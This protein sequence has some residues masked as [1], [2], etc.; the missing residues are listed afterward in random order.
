MAVSIGENP[1]VICVIC[2]QLYGSPPAPGLAT[3]TVDRG[4]LLM[5]RVCEE[6]IRLANAQR[7]RALMR[8]KPHDLGSDVRRLDGAKVVSMRAVSAAVRAA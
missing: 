5:S 8:M 4:P 7:Q 6:R 2:V 1:A 3:V